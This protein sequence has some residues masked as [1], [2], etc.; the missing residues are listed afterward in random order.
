[1]K[2]NISA[3]FVTLLLFTS[4]TLKAED[5]LPSDAYYKDNIAVNE[6]A[7][8]SP[9]LRGDGSNEVDGSVN[10]GGN[11]DLEGNAGQ[12]NAPIGD[13]ILPILV[14]GFIYSFYLLNRRRKLSV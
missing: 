12:V 9:S 13:A 10:P 4:S 2:K 5:L 11:G 3:V 1:M 6:V 14:A 8:A 7:A